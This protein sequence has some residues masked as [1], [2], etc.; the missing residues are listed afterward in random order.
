MSILWWFN[1][2]GSQVMREKDVKYPVVKF[3]VLDGFK[4]DRDITSGCFK[5]KLPMALN[6]QPKQEV[7]LKLGLKC[8]YPVHFFASWEK[9][10]IGIDLVDGVWACQ[11]ANQELEIKVKNT[12]DIPL[13]LEARETIAKFVALSNHSVKVED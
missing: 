12:K 6:L 2:K 5:V 1:K 11:D 7:L 10:A 4:P 8:N 13:L 3:T 9:K